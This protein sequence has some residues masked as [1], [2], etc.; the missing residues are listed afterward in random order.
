MTTP[1]SLPVIEVSHLPSAAS[2]YAAVAQP[3]GL[4]FLSTSTSSSL[5]TRIFFGTFD[6]T[7]NQPQT[8]FALEQASSSTQPQ[9]SSIALSAPSPAAVESFYKKALLANNAQKDHRIEKTSDEQATAKIEDLD[10]NMLEA[11]YSSRGDHM[12]TI[13][14]ASTE[15]EGRRVLAWQHEVARSTAA[16]DVHP[17]AAGNAIYRDGRPP[18]SYPR[19]DSYPPLEHERPL[20]LVRRE[21]VTEHYSTDG[22]MAEARGGGGDAFT[23]IKLVG[24]LLGAA[25]GAAIAYAMVGSESAPPPAPPTRRATYGG[26]SAGSAYMHPQLIEPVQAVEQ[27]PAQSYVSARE[28]APSRYVEYRVA[29]PPSAVLS[30]APDLARIDERSHVSSRSVK[31]DAKS[32]RARSNSEAGASQYERPLTILP[33]RDSS[34]PAAS[35]VSHRSHQ[36]HQSEQSQRPPTILPERASSPPAASH[37]SYRSHKSHQSEQSQHSERSHHTIRDAGDSS[38]QSYVSARSHRTESTVKAPASKVSTATMRLLPRDER[39]SEVSHARRIPLPRS[40]VSAVSAR[41]VPLP[42]SMVSGVGYAASL[43]P[44]DS[45][46]SVGSKRERERLRER[47]SERG[48]W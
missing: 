1:T 42:R 29:A 31:S 26:P 37:V 43:A 8:I 36:S 48:G 9:P 16:S 7:T 5:P 45:V 15:R 22:G 18:I 21:T 41:D 34:P 23:G 2:F 28:A 38:S 12:P 20:R 40:E 33:A 17:S 25:A 27:I 3:L 24:T 44:S 6:P 47:M 4:Q 10:G 11:V 39:R 30:R 32:S 19:A 13:E 46:S 14:T 35:H